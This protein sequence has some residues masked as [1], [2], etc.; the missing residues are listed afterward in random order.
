[1]DLGASLTLYASG[2]KAWNDWAARMTNRRRAMVAAGSWAWAL[3]SRSDPYPTNKETGSWWH[4]AAAQFSYHDFAD[5]PDFAGFDFP[6]PALFVAAKFPKGGRFEAARFRDGACFNYASFGA[7]VEFT[8]AE[9]C[10]YASFCNTDFLGE[11][12][13]DHCRFVPAEFEPD[14]RGRLDCTDAKCAMPV[15]FAGVNCRSAVFSDAEFAQAVSFE[16]ASFG[17]LF[18][19]YQTVFR[20]RISVRGT[21]FP[22]E[23]DWSQATLATPPIR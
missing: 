7:A 10:S 2:R 21:R 4:E 12:R 20:G 15:S 6:G 11:V 9:F 14:E 1:M 23:V 5:P 8:D 18:F 22:H 3:D 13:F 17:E 19:L 16:G